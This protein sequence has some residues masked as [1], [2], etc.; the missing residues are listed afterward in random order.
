MKIREHLLGRLGLE[1]SMRRGLGRR[2]PLDWRH[3]EKYPLSA[4]PDA[5]FVPFAGASLVGATLED[6]LDP[7][8]VVLGIAWYSSFDTP[9]RDSRGR[10]WI[11][12]TGTTSLGFLRGYHAIVAQ[13]AKIR[14]TVG[15]WRFYDQGSEGACVG[16]SL[17]RAM[18][19][20]NRDR[21][22][23]MRLYREAQTIDE[24]PGEAYSGTS[25][26]AGCEILVTR[27]PAR[28]HAGHRHVHDEDV[29]AGLSTYRWAETVDEILIALGR[30]GEDSIPLLNSWGTLYPR[31]VHLPLDVAD[32][33]MHEDGEAAL[34]TDA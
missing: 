20:L 9:K 17:A 33:L 31:V 28:V 13:P 30:Q 1:A 26:R 2:P 21:Y 19:L 24:W 25:V 27:G 5:L 7:R 32:R 18:S 22:D 15:W 4:Y 3:V 6:L 12:R 34:L 16:F 23:A 11:G 14:D 29:T 8:P 10:W